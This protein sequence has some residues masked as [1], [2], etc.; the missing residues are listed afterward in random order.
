[1]T[2]ENTKALSSHLG[3]ADP[4]FTLRTCT[5]LMPASTERTRKTVDAAFNNQDPVSTS[6]TGS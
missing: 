2:G 4:G 6:K 5:H 1:M 3:H